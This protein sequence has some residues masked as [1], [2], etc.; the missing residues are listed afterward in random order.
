VF[1][2]KRKISTKHLP[3]QIWMGERSDLHNMYW[4]N[5]FREQFR[6]AKVKNRLHI[7]IF[8]VVF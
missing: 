7:F 2:L 1:D 4:N 8:I 3:V 6:K 5:L